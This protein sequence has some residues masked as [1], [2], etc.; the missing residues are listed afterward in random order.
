MSSKKSSLVGRYEMVKLELVDD[1]SIE[2][3]VLIVR[4]TFAEM[5][6]FY[7]A[8]KDS[9]ETAVNADIREHGYQDRD[10]V[11]IG[12]TEDDLEDWRKEPNEIEAYDKAK[13]QAEREG[14]MR[15]VAVETRHFFPGDPRSWVAALNGAIEAT[16]IQVE[17][18]AMVVA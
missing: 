11:D 17:P 13:R 15:F 2:K 7:E 10:G 3:K 12:W 5:C 6:G 8:L 1:T 9:M 18:E 16:G 4:G 14:L